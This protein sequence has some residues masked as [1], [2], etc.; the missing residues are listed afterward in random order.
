MKPCQRREAVKKMQAAGASERRAC[1]L[2]GQHRSTQAPS[3]N[4]TQS[5]AAPSHTGPVYVV[6]CPVCHRKFK[7]KTRTTT[8]N[9]HKNDSGRACPG[10]QGRMVNIE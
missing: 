9:A 3:A 10:R 5:V 2:A 7:R 4:A 1:V 6:E 8:L